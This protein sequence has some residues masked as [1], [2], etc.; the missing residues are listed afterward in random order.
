MDEHAKPATRLAELPEETQRFLAQLD[1]GDI[2]ALKQGLE[3]IRSLLTVGRFTKWVII[4]IVGMFLGL[5]M[6]GEGVQKVL[7][8]WSSKM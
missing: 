5:V 6:V 3:L 7:A 4:T 1:E 8:W 2:V